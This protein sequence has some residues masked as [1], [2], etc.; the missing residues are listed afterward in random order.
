LIGDKKFGDRLDGVEN[1]DQY[2]DEKQREKRS[3]RATHDEF[4]SSLFH[5]LTF[6]YLLYPSN[7]QSNF[8]QIPRSSIEKRF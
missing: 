4:N 7:F 5:A 2:I 6:P 1:I 8:P 3:L